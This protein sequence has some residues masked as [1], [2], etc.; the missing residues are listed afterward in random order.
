MKKY[1]NIQEPY[2]FLSPCVAKSDEF[3]DP[4]T[5]GLIE[6]NVTFK[7]LLQQLSENGVDYS[8]YTPAGYDNEAHGMGSVYSS[9][10]GLKTNVEQ[11]VQDQWIFQI[12]GQPYVHNFLHEYVKERGDVPFLV[13]ILNC[14]HGCNVGT[15]ACREKGEEYTVDRSMHKVKRDV[16]ENKPDEDKLPGPDFTEFDKKLKLTDFMRRYTPKK[17]SPIFV[18]RSELE[19][20]FASMHKPSHEF[21]THDCR[22]CGY[23]TCQEMAVAIAKGI[24]YKENCIDYYRGVLKNS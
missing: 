9:P 7:K 17:I 11:H 10:G 21:R 18:D 12:E 4:N 16:L 23:G 5:G 6:Y 14:L 8:K 22:R 1:E 3:G 2:A 20:A 19:N 15:G 13:D 24:N